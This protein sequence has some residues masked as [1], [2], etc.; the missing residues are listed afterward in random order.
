M[1]SSTVAPQNFCLLFDGGPKKNKTKEIDIESEPPTVNT[2]ILLHLSTT[3][4]LQK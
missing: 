2:I 4:D 1:S 3:S